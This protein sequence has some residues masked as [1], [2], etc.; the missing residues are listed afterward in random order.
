MDAAAQLHRRRRNTLT[1]KRDSLRRGTVQRLLQQ[2]LRRRHR[3]RIR[4]RT[5]LLQLRLPRVRQIQSP[6]ARQEQLPPARIQHH[7]LVP[8]HGQLQITRALEPV[9]GGGLGRRCLTVRVHG[10]DGH[11]ARLRISTVNPVVGSHR[12]H[13]SLRS[14]QHGFRGLLVESVHGGRREG[15]DLALRCVGDG[16][17]LGTEAHICRTRQFLVATELH[18]GRGHLVQRG[19]GLVV[20]ED[21]TG[22][23]QDVEGSAGGGH[24]TVKHARGIIQPANSIP[25]LADHPHAAVV[26]FHLSGLEPGINHRT[27]HQRSTGHRKNGARNQLPA[28]LPETQLAEQSCHKFSIPSKSQ[29]P[30]GQR[31]QRPGTGLSV[32]RDSLPNQPPDRDGE[33][34]PT[35]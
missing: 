27:R 20:D 6:P 12:G 17:D 33:L 5:R 21:V 10:R 3:H 9:P 26:Q 2:R 7:R 11:G 31:F 15:P 29:P 22:V 28:A 8:H 23:L 30:P 4:G 13:G 16:N 18:V 34:S 25:G 1:V 24:C 14:G 19:A 35:A 32:S